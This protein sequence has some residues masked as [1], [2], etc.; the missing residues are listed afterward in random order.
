MAKIST[1]PVDGLISTDDFIIGSDAENVNITKNFTV[2]GIL[3]LA[4][5]QAVLDNGNSA[6]QNITLVGN[7][8]ATNV[9]ATT[10]LSAPTA[11]VTNANVTGSLTVNDLEVS[12]LFYDSTASEGTNG[13]ILK[14]TGSGVEWFTLAETQN[15][16][17]VLA[18]GNT[19]S[20]NI[21]ST[22]DITVDGFT[23]NSQ[24][25]ITGTIEA[26]SSIG[27]AGQVLVSQG[28]AGS[29]QWATI[30]ETQDLQSVL[31]NGNSAT[32]DI[33]LTGTIEAITLTVNS[34][35]PGTIDGKGDIVWS[36]ERGTL[37][38]GLVDNN[39]MNVGQDNIWLV[40]ANSA[41]TK[42]QVVYAYGTVGASG[43]IVVEKYLA[44][45]SIPSRY[46]IGIAI[47]DI[48]VSEEGYVMS[49]GK[50]KGINTSTYTEGD[51]LWCDPA[52]AGGLTNVEPT[53]P[54]IKSAM[55]FVI[56]ADNNGTIAVR[57]DSGF[58]ISDASD[59]NFTGVAD[60]DVILRAGGVWTNITPSADLIATTGGAVDPLLT[61]TAAIT[62]V[63]GLDAGQALST[64]SQWL[65]ITI[66]SVDYVIPAYLS[67]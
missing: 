2:G 51:V 57:T 14:S 16:Q 32:E 37:E 11:N 6:T 22:G 50:I 10:L 63:I 1:Y 17:A 24:L 36:E 12:G 34:S 13:Q 49:L 53:A 62:D 60:G 26:N 48:N 52:V 38:V 7:V 5:L 35:T 45:G 44:D 66:N 33:V 58:V 21:V 40:R 25:S 19:T 42:G 47:A 64:P 20:L 61:Q 59:V 56:S 54:D 65:T 15:L 46:I 30:T 55:A 28:G 18:S 4:N 31:D 41:I 43:K 67:A 9:S 27:T 8:A 23:V 3:S 39:T 29:V